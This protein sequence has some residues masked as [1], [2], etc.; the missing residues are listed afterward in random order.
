ML[1][2]T[3]LGLKEIADIL[4]H[5]KNEKDIE[6]NLRK[7]GDKYLARYLLFREYKQLTFDQKLKEPIVPIIAAMPCVGKTTLA[8]EVATA[9]GI[10]NV[11]GGDSFRAALREL[12]S[13]EENPAFFTSVYESWKAFGD[14]TKENI[15]KGF[16]AQA[17]VMNQA[18]ERIVADRGIRDGESVVVEYLHFLPS[19]WSKEVIEYPAIIPIVL[20]TDSINIYKSRME[21]RDKMTHFKG[22]ASRLI[23]VADKYLVMQE[24]QCDDARKH[25]IPVVSTDNWEKAYDMI[26]DIIFE[27]IDKLIRSGGF[28]EPAIVKKLREERK[29]LSDRM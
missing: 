11:M 10:G 18:I 23:A 25:H 15:L 7:R 12:I 8:R 9:F 22:N 2:C 19:Q 17:K 5:S 16:E 20:R 28:E 14:E 27:R 1:L 6:E 29:K 3:G 13:K 21:K 24:L 26:L 4:T